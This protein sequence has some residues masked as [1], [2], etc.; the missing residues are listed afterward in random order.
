MSSR[1]KLS[2][3]CIIALCF[4]FFANFVPALLFGVCVNNE[5]RPDDSVSF[6]KSGVDSVICTDLPNDSLKRF[7]RFDHSDGAFN[8]FSIRLSMFISS[9]ERGYFY[10]VAR[11]SE[12]YIKDKSEIDRDSAVFMT[13]NTD[14]ARTLRVFSDLYNQ[15]L[16]ERKILSKTG[17]VTDKNPASPSGIPT[18]SSAQVSC[19]GNVYTYPAGTTGSAPPPVMGYP[20]YGCLGSEPCPAYYYMQVSVP[21]DIIIFIDQ[22]SHD[23]DFICWGPFN[24]LT[25]GC[26]FGL[27]GTCNV[28]LQPGCCNNNQTG[29][30]NFYPRGNITD[31]SYSG[32]PTETCHILNA[33]VGQIYILLITNFSTLAGTITFQQTGGLGVTDCNIVMHCSMIAMTSVPSI[34]DGATNTFS[35]SG[36]VEFSNPPPTGTLTV[37]DNTAVPPVSQI[38]FPPFISPLAYN[39]AGIPCDGLVHSFTAAFSDSV[40]CTMTDQFTSP[41]ASCPQAII[42]GGGEICNDGVSTV[43]VNISLV[44]ISP[45]NFTYAINGVPQPP[46][47]NYGGASPYV[48]NTLVPGTYTLL[49]ISNSICT[50][51]GLISGSAIVILDPL[52]SLTLTGS[53]SV[54]TGSTG[55]VYSTDVGNS[56][57]QWA[58]SAGGAITSGGTASDNTVTVTW[59]TP[60]SQSVSINYHDAHGCTAAS[61]F[62]LPVTVNSLPV[63]VIAGNNN[64]CTGST[65]NVYTTLPGMSNY[66]WTVSA[67]GTITAGGTTSDPSVTVTWNTPGVET[68]SVNFNDGNNCRASAPTVYLVTVH[69]LPIPAIAGTN[70]LCAG[71]TG[72]VYSTQA[73]MTNYQWL[74]SAGGTISSGGTAFDNTVT[75]TWNTP[76]AQSVSVNSQDAFGCTALTPVS[77]PVTVNS[78]P[79]P[80]ITGPVAVC[81]NSTSSYSTDAGMSNYTW[82]VSAGGSIT[83][84]NGTSSITVLWNTTGAKTIS[85]NYS[86]ANSCFAAVP[87]AYL[88]NV[89]NLP[90]PSLTGT[91]SVC[92]GLSVLYTSD[93]GMTGYSW[94]VSAGG[95]ITAG[96]TATDHTASVTWNTAGAQSVSVNYQVGPGCSAALPTVLPITVKPRPSV[97]NAANSTVCSATNLAIIPQASLPGTTFSWTASGSSANVTGYLPGGGTAINDHLVNSGFNIETVT[98]SVT[99]SLNGCDGSNSDYIVTVNPVADVIFTPNGQT[100]CSGVFTAISLGSNVPLPSFT[101]TANGSSGNITGY[102]TGA[103]NTISQQLTNTGLVN[104]ETVIYH[105]QPAINGC[106]GT[107]S[108]V[109]VTVTPLPPTEFTPCTDITTTT[110]AKP[111]TLKGGI[112]MGGAYSGLGVNAGIFYPSLA[113]PGTHTLVYSYTNVNGCTST[114]SVTISVMGA[115][116]FTCDDMYTDVRDNTQYPSIKIGT[117]CWMASNL[118]YGSVI[119]SASMQRDNCLAEKYCLNDNV[120]NCSSLGGLYQWDKVMQFDATA[121]NQGICPPAWHVPTENEWTTLFNYYTS[122]GFAGSPLKSSGY[123]GFNALLSGIRFDNRNWFFSNFATFIWSSTSQGPTK[124]WAHAMNSIN[125][126][127]SYYPANRSNAFSVRCIKD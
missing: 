115:P 45:F 92:N 7:V 127:V 41:P 31:C 74:V 96:G 106:Q 37:T 28:P 34:C 61:A 47:N 91:N 19:S 75:V 101:W 73:G 108:N 39:L 124:A 6:I 82:S 25:E 15:T 111:I 117:Q 58:V 42:S 99:P 68:V 65:G 121:G 109:L 46:V 3:S 87:S 100:F 14:R 79:A 13:G 54:C 52:P 20:N 38:L 71:T 59:N 78:L 55:I 83:I 22:G 60:G 8:Y 81:L 56:N 12:I 33:Q 80:G 27:T 48:I 125:P 122:S 44:G 21:G 93:I 23:V 77:Y 116:G 120:A 118:N 35:V 51:P 26:D 11:A 66:S 88:V 70:I 49:S 95:T 67:G 114:A 69:F 90:V 43:P 126:S 94:T 63:P 123:S 85:V 24:S 30:T 16:T 113:G 57:Y 105:V 50:G 103:G 2:Q 102:G 119:S 4:A 17:S 112:P 10:Q 1:K 76:G 5:S 86:D 29:C 9:H 18:C 62:V 107:Q 98:Y 110:D 89:S 53:G 104:N 36:N 40:T 72:T 84:G 32:N 97:T 64:L